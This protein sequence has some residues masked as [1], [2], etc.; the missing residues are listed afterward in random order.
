MNEYYLELPFDTDDPEFTRGVEV[1]MLW[2]WL[3]QDSIIKHAQL[4]RVSN[5]EMALRMAE[6]QG[7]RLTAEYTADEGWAWA[8]FERLGQ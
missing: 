7:L 5:L 2:A 1:G 4:V 6:S 8:T 3:S